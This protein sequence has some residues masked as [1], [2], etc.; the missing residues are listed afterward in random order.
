M[1]FRQLPQFDK[2][3]K[4]LGKAWT[5]KDMDLIAAICAKNVKYYE[6]PFGKPYTS[7]A[8]VKKLWQ[9]V[10]DNQKDIMFKYDIL[11]VT[12]TAGIAHWQAEYTRIKNN[13]R[14]ALDGVV[15]VEFNKEGLCT[16]LRK[17]LMVK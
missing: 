12:I 7:P 9:E 8:A 14:V 13:E 3:L 16:R 1:K 11:A 17:W 2:W 4:N 6:T 5:E 15:Y 10:P